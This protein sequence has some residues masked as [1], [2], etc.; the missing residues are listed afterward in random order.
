MK[1]LKRFL[2]IMS[3]TKFRVEYLCYAKIKHS[4]WLKIGFGLGTANQSVLF[5]LS[6]AI[7]LRCS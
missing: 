7:Q 1:K 5:Q 6:I 2:E 4:V 3:Q